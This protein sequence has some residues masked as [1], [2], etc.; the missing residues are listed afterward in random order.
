MFLCEKI[1]SGLLKNNR[2]CVLV[3]GLRRGL[4]SIGQVI[5]GTSGY[6]NFG[7]NVCCPGNWLKFKR[8]SK[9]NVMRQDGGNSPQQR[10]T[11]WSS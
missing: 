7:E 5:E 2:E 10:L 11:V 1:S 3:R 4:V 6:F 9:G 8:T